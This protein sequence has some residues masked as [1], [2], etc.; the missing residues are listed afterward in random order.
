MGV[1]GFDLPINA[2]P[3]NYAPPQITSM[4]P[5]TAQVG[6]PYRYDVIATNPENVQLTYSFVGTPPADMTMDSFGQH[7][8][9][10]AGAARGRRHRADSGH[11]RLGWRGWANLRDRNA[12]ADRRSGAGDHVKG[13]G[14]ATANQDYVYQAQAYRPVGNPLTWTLLEAPPET[15]IE[16]GDGTDAPTL[17]S[18]PMMLRSLILPMPL[19]I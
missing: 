17:S 7:H 11:G 10:A 12:V 8:L 5:T 1:Q 9:D 16:P 14:D 15:V 3:A 13:T 2:A 6:T 4:A 19:S 18:L